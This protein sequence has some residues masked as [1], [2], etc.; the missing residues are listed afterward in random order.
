MNKKLFHDTDDT[1]DLKTSCN[2]GYHVR[3]LA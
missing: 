2:I 3:L 1:C